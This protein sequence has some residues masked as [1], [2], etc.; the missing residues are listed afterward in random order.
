MGQ[1][2][3]S[4]PGL[5]PLHLRVT[6]ASA[7]A[8]VTGITDPTNPLGK[9]IR[10]RR[11]GRALITRMPFHQRVPGLLGSP[12]PGWMR[13]DAQ[14]VHGLGLDLYHEQHIQALEQHGVYMQEVTLKDAGRLG[15]H[16]PVPKPS[17]SP[18]MRR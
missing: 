10:P 15:R 11:P 4:V 3:V 14:D 8:L 16:H 13:G 7:D 18:W 6:V 5:E 12:G 9:C 17:G 2:V 1:W